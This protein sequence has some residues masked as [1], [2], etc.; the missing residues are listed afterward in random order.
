MAMTRT[1]PEWRVRVKAGDKLRLNG[2]YET[3][4]ASW[5]EGMAIMMAA[6]AP[7]D[8]SGVDP[9]ATVRVRRRVRPPRRGARRR[10]GVRCR[11]V[12]RPRRSRRS[13]RARRVCFRTVRRAVPIDLSGEPTH[14]HLPENDNY[15]GERVRPL[16]AQEGPELDRIGIGYFR[17][18]A[19]DLSSVDSEGIPRVRLGSRLTFS[20]YDAFAGI[21]HTIT[22]CKPPCTGATGISYPIADDDSR[23]D[24]LELGYAPQVG[25]LLQPVAN[26]HE[27]AIEPERDGLR[28]GSTYTYFCRIHPF[29]RGAFKVVP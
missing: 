15:G 29:M 11:R 1:D 27:Y 12:G 28:A 26:N 17:Y 23:L 6:I 16:P 2:V 20:N 25:P 10:V 18:S 7:G 9:F 19:G 4:R 8:E 14:G 5:Y 3:D 24:S 22:T 21:W 13:R